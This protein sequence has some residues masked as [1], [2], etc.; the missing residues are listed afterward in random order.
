[1]TTGSWKNNWISTAIVLK[2]TE[3]SFQT[4]ENLKVEMYP[5]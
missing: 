4:K 3:Q 1:M 2:G 5:L